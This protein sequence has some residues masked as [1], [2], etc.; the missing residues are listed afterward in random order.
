[1]KLQLKDIKIKFPANRAE[2]Y[3]ILAKLKEVL[4]AYREFPQ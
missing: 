1:M 3:Q 4:Y 2:T